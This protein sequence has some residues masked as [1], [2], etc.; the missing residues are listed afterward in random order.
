MRRPQLFSLVARISAFD[1][2]CR[3]A[4]NTNVVYLRFDDNLVAFG[5]MPH[6]N[7][8]RWSYPGRKCFKS[9]VKRVNSDVS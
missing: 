4:D 2:A 1:D 5:T 9:G 7:T 8:A 6:L 3:C